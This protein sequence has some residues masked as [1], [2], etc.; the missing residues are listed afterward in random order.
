MYSSLWQKEPIPSFQMK[1]HDIVDNE[2]IRFQS[3]LF[4]PLVCGSDLQSWTLK[5]HVWKIYISV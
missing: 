5:P 3:Q 2:L 1:L 4:S